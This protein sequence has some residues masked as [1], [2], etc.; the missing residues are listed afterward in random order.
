MFLSFTI[1]FLALNDTKVNFLIFSQGVLLVLED[2][3]H[4]GAKLADFTNTVKLDLTVG[5]HLNIFRW[6]KTCS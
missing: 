5:R 6:N 4:L 2:F 3:A 1:R